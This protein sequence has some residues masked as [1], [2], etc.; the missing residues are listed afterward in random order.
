MQ[1]K[2][3]NCSSVFGWKLLYQTAQCPLCLLTEVGH[4]D[5]CPGSNICQIPE[6]RQGSK[7][8]ADWSYWFNT[9][10]LLKSDG[11]QIFFHFLWLEKKPY[12]HLL[13]VSPFSSVPSQYTG[14][15]GK[16]SDLSYWQT[17]C[18]LWPN[19]SSFF[20]LIILEWYKPFSDASKNFILMV[21][22]HFPPNS[23]LRN[24]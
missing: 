21:I 14:E 1:A 23:S 8:K 19:I 15:S 3:S 16:Q 17:Q 7:L 4:K 18:E 2:E 11:I 24:K 13:Q 22:W 12:K 10:L 20:N 6:V 9:V 5:T